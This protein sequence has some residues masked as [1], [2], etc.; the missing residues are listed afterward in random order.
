M[1]LTKTYKPNKFE[2]NATHCTKTTKKLLLYEQIKW[3]HK[4]IN[5]KT[6]KCIYSSKMFQNAK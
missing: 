5:E 2:K 6:K 4:I 3:I 1:N